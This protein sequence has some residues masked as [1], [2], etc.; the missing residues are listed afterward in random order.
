VEFAP[1]RLTDT[2]ADIIVLADDIHLGERVFQWARENIRTKKVFYVLG[3]HGFCREATP[4][5]FEKLREKT[6]GMNI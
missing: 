4:R 1:Y 3:N 2:D 6:K 5:L